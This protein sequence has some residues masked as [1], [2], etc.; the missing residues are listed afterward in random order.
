LLA[1]SSTTSARRPAKFIRGKRVRGRY[2]VGDGLEP[3]LNPKGRAAIHFAVDAIS[4]PS[5]RIVTPRKYGDRLGPRGYLSR[6]DWSALMGGEIGVH[7][8]VNRGFDFCSRC[9]SSPSPT[10]Y[11]PDAL[12]PNKTS[13]AC[14]ALVVDDNAQHRAILQKHLGVV[15]HRGTA[16]EPAPRLWGP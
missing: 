3:H 16:A 5:G 12:A 14:A 15:G 10:R 1:L 11:D 8:E 13:P 7:S 2:R 4:P 9:G 6:D